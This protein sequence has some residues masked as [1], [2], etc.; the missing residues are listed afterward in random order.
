V[1]VNVVKKPYSAVFSEFKGV[2]ANPR[3]CRARAT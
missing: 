3:T 1:L 2:S